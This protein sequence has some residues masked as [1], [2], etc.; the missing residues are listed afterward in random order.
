MELN[1][2]PR[3]RSLLLHVISENQRNHEK[4]E[5]SG[6]IKRCLLYLKTFHY[7]MLG[8]AVIALLRGKTSKSR[9]ELPSSANS[10]L[11]CTPVAQQ[12]PIREISAYEANT[13]SCS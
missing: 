6:F 3:M 11:Q 10:V 12:D 13:T 9:K 7:L 5:T 2:Y 8:L 1:V 4:Q